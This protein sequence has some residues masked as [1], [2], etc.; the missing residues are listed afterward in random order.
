MKRIGIFLRKVIL[1]LLLAA[2]LLLLFKPVYMENGTCSGSASA[3]LLE[4]TECFF[5]A[6]RTSSILQELLV[7]LH[8]T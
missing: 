7:Y 3:F 1:P 4:S 6:C 8:L 5:G 2:L